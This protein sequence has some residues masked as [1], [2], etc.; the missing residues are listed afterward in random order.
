MDMVYIISDIGDL[1]TAHLPLHQ[2]I[3]RVLEAQFASVVCCV[4]GKLAYY[5]PEAPANGY[6]LETPP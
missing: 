2:A 4:S 6:I 3:E 5:R 1:D